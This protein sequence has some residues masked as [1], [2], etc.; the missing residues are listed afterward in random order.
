MTLSNSQKQ[1]RFRKKEYLQKL[2]NNV[3]ITWQLSNFGIHQETPEEKRAELQKII[4]LPPKWT[5]DDYNHALRILA[6]YNNELLGN[7]DFLQND[8]N[9]GRETL[10]PFATCSNPSKK[11]TDDKAAVKNMRNLSAY[12]IKTLDLLDGYASNNAVALSDYAAAIS[13]V[14]RKLG[15]N[16]AN[17]RIVPKSHATTLCL[18]AA[19]HMNRPNWF[20]QELVDIL[21]NNLQPELIEELTTKLI[22]NIHQYDRFMKDLAPVLKK[23]VPQHFIKE[24]IDELSDIPE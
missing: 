1:E 21:K 13:D 10:N 4:D 17:T 14:Q 8:V 20:I 18:L 23:N 7:K 16:L 6:N 12:I 22:S 2:A 15:R 19:P 5:D 11:I 24:L 9:H 3:F